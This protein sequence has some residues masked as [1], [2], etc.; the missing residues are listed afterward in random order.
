MMCYHIQLNPDSSNLQEKSR[1]IQVVGRLVTELAIINCSFSLILQSLGV[2]GSFWF[3][4]F[5]NSWFD[6]SQQFGLSSGVSLNG[7]HNSRDR[8]CPI[9]R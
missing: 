2:C 6:K 1:K 3:Y 7:V 4:F 8:I 5:F 9:A